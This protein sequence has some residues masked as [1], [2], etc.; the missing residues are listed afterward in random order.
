MTSRL[1]K[2]YFLSTVAILTVIGLYL[3]LPFYLNSYAKNQFATYSDYQ[4]SYSKISLSVLQGSYT[5]H[6]IKLQKKNAPGREHFF[7]ADRIEFGIRWTELFKG[8]ITGKVTVHSP[9]INFIREAGLG[10]SQLNADYPWGNIGRRLLGV[11]LDQIEIKNG[12]L[13]YQDLQT[14]PHTR[15]GM[16]EININVMD[17]ASENNNEGNLM[18]KAFGDA[19]VYDGQLN[20]S[21]EFDAASKKPT[22]DVKASLE[23]LDL[24]YLRDYLK[25][26]GDYTIEKGLF[27]MVAQASG[28]EES[29]SGFVKPLLKT[30]NLVSNATGATLSHQV[31][32]PF[33]RPFPQTSF[34]GDLAA[35]SLTLWGAV[36]FT[37]RDAFFE[38]V[39]PVIRKINS[40]EKRPALKP[41]LTPSPMKENAAT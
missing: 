35:G 22:F 4:A 12:S 8:R 31:D 30:I 39:M 6:E 21:L 14:I 17:L 20:F 32:S 34:R 26:H 16:N 19:R 7:T 36:A 27:S 5:L 24:A 1:F 3:I 37:L 9:T 11:T 13:T 2:L 38:A 15:L 10:K 23:N 25:A 29:I 18:A 41:R 33:A 28:E 40:V